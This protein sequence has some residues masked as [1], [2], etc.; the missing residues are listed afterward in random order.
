MS[1]DV[2]SIHNER[3]WLNAMLVLGYSDA[4][5]LVKQGI[6]LKLTAEEPAVGGVVARLGS[7]QL[8]A[9]APIV[10]PMHAPSNQPRLVHPKYKVS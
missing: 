8:H 7:M 6:K 10:A 2:L 4:E 3:T 1:G 9:D 5:K